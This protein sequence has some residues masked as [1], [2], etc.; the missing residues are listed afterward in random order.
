MA[1]SV[2]PAQIGQQF[3]VARVG[4]PR[5]GQR[6]LVQRRRDDAVHPLSLSQLTSN[7]H[8]FVRRLASSGVHL[9]RRQVDH[10]VITAAEAGHAL[11]R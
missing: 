8:G 9:R 11:R 1:T 3:G 2:D 10:A 4:M 6:R 5:G 7:C